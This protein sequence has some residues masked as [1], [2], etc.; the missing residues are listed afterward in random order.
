MSTQEQAQHGYSIDEQV[1]RMQKYCES[2]S[3]SVY[4]S[5]V[6]AGFSGSNMERPALKQLI[7]D[8]QERR[9]D[10]VLVYKL[11]RLS[12]SQKDTLYLI[13]DVFVASGCGFASMNENFDTG[14]PLGI[15]MIGILSVFAQLERS[16]ITERMMLGKEARAKQGKFAGGNHIPIGYDYDQERGYLVVNEFEAMQVKRVFKEYLSGKP[17]FTIAKDLNE[18]GLNHK[19]GEWSTRTIRNVLS[20]RTYLGELKYQKEW[21]KS[22]H[23]PLITEEEHLEALRLLGKSTR[24][25]AQVKSYLGGLLFCKQCG[26]RYSKSTANM[27]ASGKRL[28]YYACNNRTRKTPSAKQHDKCLNKTWKMEEL[29]ELIFGEIRKLSLA[30]E[31]PKKQEDHRDEII[32]SEI[33]KI[34]R[35]IDRL[36]DLYSIGN[37]SVNSLN[38]KIGSLNAQ[39]AKLEAELDYLRKSSLKDKTAFKRQIESFSDMLE[40]GT[41]DQI[42]RI[43]KA[44]IRKIELDGEDIYIYWNFS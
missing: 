17:I 28:T 25:S 24:N 38:S 21:H 15:A 8:V 41:P 31:E 7:H 1:S 5:Y 3:W 29:D 32:S 37:L 16:Q 34:E 40:A 13:E 10:K 19:F 36:I 30:P 2:M 43:V 26:A 35:Q 22:E 12:R 4:R 9:I 11:D 39:K 27:S 33:K 20:S 18:A 23:T 14:S 42:R 6:D 44:L